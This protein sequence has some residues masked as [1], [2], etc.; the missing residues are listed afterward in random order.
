MTTEERIKL[1]EQCLIELVKTVNF[2]DL[3]E[4]V[5]NYIEL[6]ESENELE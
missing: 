6:I 1:I 5:R 2:S 3:P 4:S